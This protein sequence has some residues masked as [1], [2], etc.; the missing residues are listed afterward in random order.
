EESA[1]RQE[2]EEREE[3]RRPDARAQLAAAREQQ[4]ERSRERERQEEVPQSGI[5]EEMAV[6]V[7]REWPRRDEE[8]HRERHVLAELQQ[9]LAE[10]RVALRE[11]VGGEVE[12]VREDALARREVER[13]RDGDGGD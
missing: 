2:E 10:R 7:D 9:P 12:A 1:R 11:A 4:C 13:A 8:P 5:A 3:Q 6:V